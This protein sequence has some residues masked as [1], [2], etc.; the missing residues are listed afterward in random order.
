L[1]PKPR[2]SPALLFGDGNG[3]DEP[4]APQG[5]LSGEDDVPPSDEEVVTFG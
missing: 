1:G 3:G 4:K 5:T 2:K